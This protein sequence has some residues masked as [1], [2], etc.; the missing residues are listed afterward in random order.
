[1]APGEEAHGPDVEVIR[2]AY[3]AFDFDDLGGFLDQVAED[4]EWVPPSYAPEPSPRKGREAI[5]RGLEAYREGFDQFRPEPQRILEGG[6]SGCYLVLVNT[7]TRGKGSGVETTI[8]VGHVIEVRE[9][10]VT[11]LE[12]H[13]DLD[14]ARR[15]AGLDPG[16]A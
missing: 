16:S 9:G 2:S 11:R 1:M 3:E 8:H 7:H 10:K 12:V 14:D 4:V 15:A 5:E 6:R 13:P